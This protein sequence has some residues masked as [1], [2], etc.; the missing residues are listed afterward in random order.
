MLILICAIKR[1]LCFC[2]WHSLGRSNFWCGSFFI[3]RLSYHAIFPSFIA[4]IVGDYV[5]DLWKIQ[6]IHYHI[7]FIP[8]IT[9]LN[10]LYSILA[11]IAFGL[12]GRFFAKLT[13]VITEFS[14]SKISYPPLRPFTGRI[15][16]AIAIYLIGTTKYIGLGMSTIVTSFNEQ[17]PAYDFLVKIL[18][19]AVTL[20]FDFKG[21]EVTPPCF[22][23]VQRLE[24]RCLFSFRCLYWQE[25]ASL[26]CLQELQILR[27]PQH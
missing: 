5:C 14:K 13:H 26:L 24:M 16:V 7:D 1:R 23:L 4:A 8:G 3:G 11:G 6:H 25:W 19:T 21:G 2:V 18:F 10:L 22:L 27:L 15:I 12:T 20:G 17:L 9:G